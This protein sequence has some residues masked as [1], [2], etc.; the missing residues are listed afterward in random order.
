MGEVIVLGIDLAKS[1]FQ[2]HGNDERGKR[3]LGKALNRQQLGAFVANLAP[4]T[5][6]MEACASAHWWAGRFAA[7]GHTVKLI[8]PQHVKPYVKGNKN[9][10]ADAEAIAEAASR[11]SMR[12]VPVKTA[13][14]LDLQA[15]HRV[16]SRLVGQRTA[17]TNEMRGFLFEHG[18]A[19]SQGIANLKSFVATLSNGESQ[20]ITPMCRETLVDL[21]AELTDLEERIAVCNRRLESF[22]KDHETVKRLLTVPGVGLITATA[23]VAAVPNPRDFRN[24]RQFSA[25]IGLVPRHSGT[26]GADKNRLGRISKRGD[27]YLRRLLVHGARSVLKVIDKRTD[28]YG[29]WAAQLKA[30]KGWNKT[31]VAMANKNARIIWSL[32][33]GNVDYEINHTPAASSRAA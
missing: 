4:C 9:D 30:Q 10:R 17:L 13:V 31:V 33:S 2:L 21:L 20:D 24:G 12:F 23:M 28:R 8:A 5:I 16:R 1:S 26:G 19:L 6:A 15:I 22:G 18:I 11:P 25:W 14:H 3:V 32:M 7:H 27:A 29:I